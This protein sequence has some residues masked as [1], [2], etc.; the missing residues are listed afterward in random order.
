MYVP[1]PAIEFIY[2][3]SLYR[4]SYYMDFEDPI[5]KIC[6]AT[7]AEPCVREK[8]LV[9]IRVNLIQN[10]YSTLHKVL[11]TKITMLWVWAENIFSVFVVYQI[12]SNQINPSNI[13]R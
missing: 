2:I 3:F 13:F 8:S 11:I 12:S 6:S 7:V 4:I 9:D 10:V 5:L 1:G